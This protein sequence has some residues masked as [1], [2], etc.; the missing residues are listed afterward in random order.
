[1]RGDGV[2][3][4]VAPPN[5]VL[6]VSLPKAGTYLVA[7]V[8]KAL[9]YGS[10]GMHLAETAYSDYNGAELDEARRNPG[11]FARREPLSQSV[12]RIA[13]GRFAVGHLPCKKEIVQATAS[14]KRIYLT[15]DLR[16][17]LI[18]YMR[19]LAATGRLGAK[20]LSWYAIADPKARVVDF[21]RTSAPHLLDWFYKGLAGWSQVPGALCVHFEDL[22][23]ERE[24]APH[25]V[26][27][28]AAFLGRTPC[29][30]RRILSS[31]LASETIT[32]S[33]GLTQLAD[34]W[35]PEAERQFI[36]IGGP[37][38]NARLGCRQTTAA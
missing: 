17:A 12:L 27:S 30:A 36:S 32:K 20:E 7:E 11:R 13:A 16:T 3:Q 9:G 22:M 6:V 37:E 10:T 28:I 33:D 21:L 19:F 4:S 26:E 1:M 29:D 25:A 34:Y 31:S 2:A 24:T 38:L 23:H 5:R 15:R 35:S 8:L 18:S 14:F